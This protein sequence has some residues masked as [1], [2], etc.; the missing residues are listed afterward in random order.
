M[1]RNGSDNRIYRK[2]DYV[3]LAVGHEYIVVN[4]EKI[5]KEGHTH[6]QSFSQAQ[7]LIRMASAKKVPNHLSAYLLVSLIRIS[8]DESYKAQIQSLLDEKNDKKKGNKRY[9]N[10]PCCR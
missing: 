6:V 1:K 2:G 10:A 4:R 5:F 7:Y 3:I 8:D 9:F